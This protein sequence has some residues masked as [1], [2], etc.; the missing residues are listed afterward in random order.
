MINDLKRVRKIDNWSHVMRR[1]SLT[2]LQTTCDASRRFKALSHS[3]LKYFVLLISFDVIGS[4]KFCID[5][6][7]A[8][9]AIVLIRYIY[10]GTLLKRSLPCCFRCPR[11]LSFLNSLAT[12]SK[13]L[14]VSPDKRILIQSKFSP[15]PFPSMQRLP[16]FQWW[17]LEG[18]RLESA[19]VWPQWT[20]DDCSALDSKV[21]TC[22]Y[23]PGWTCKFLEFQKPF[24]LLFED[25]GWL[26][27]MISV[28]WSLQNAQNLWILNF[29][30]LQIL[31]AW[32]AAKI[33]LN[34]SWKSG[35]L[36]TQQCCLEGHCQVRSI[37][38]AN[39]ED[40]ENV[41]ILV[42]WNSAKMNFDKSQNSR[43]LDALQY[44]LEGHSQVKS[45]C[46]ANFDNLKNVK[47]FE[48]RWPRKVAKTFTP[49]NHPDICWWAWFDRNDLLG[50][51]CN[52][53][54]NN[55]ENRQI[56]GKLLTPECTK[57]CKIFDAE[58]H[59][60]TSCGVALYRNVHPGSICTA[61]FN[62]LKKCQNF[63]KVLTPKVVE[64][65]KKFNSGESFWY[66]L[67]R[68]DVMECLS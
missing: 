66:L 21:Y 36:D 10:P 53:N 59:S 15:A 44:C 42:L 8:S 7:M 68:K 27:P 25:G 54:F 64:S 48:M 41:K 31:V 6:L 33:S 5:P 57:S 2:A 32:N 30:F 63:G 45:I 55:W 49:E 17:N 4:E 14:G 67:L 26:N 16:N 11:A 39:F 38:T 56:F 12:L 58:N 37:Y 65:C 35:G 60:N 34:K 24:Q 40:M 28:L 47:F 43:V 29:Q 13:A 18:L 3:M 23:F 1:V 50:S 9:W 22:S 20:Y 46:S 52:A 62:D 51:T 19:S 61:D